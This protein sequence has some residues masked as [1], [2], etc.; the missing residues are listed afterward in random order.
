MQRILYLAIVCSMALSH[1]GI[2]QPRLALQVPFFIDLPD[3]IQGPVEATLNTFSFHDERGEFL[4]DQIAVQVPTRLGFA[5]APG[6]VLEVQVTA[7]GYWS[8]RYAL[9]RSLE[10]GPVRGQLFV[11]GRISGKLQVPTGEH[12]P[13]ALTARFQQAA[14]QQTDAPLP[15]GTVECP[16]V[17]GNFTCTLP[18]GK[19]DLRLRAAGFVS[20]Y[21]WNLNVAPGVNSPLGILQLERGGSVVGEVHGVMANTIG[22]IE[23]ALELVQGGGGVRKADKEQFVRLNL[24]T[25]PNSHGFFQIADVPQ[26]QYRVRAFHEKWGDAVSLPITVF[27]NGETRLKKPLA[28]RPLAAL[29]LLI[30]PP[31]DPYGQPWW[32]ELYQSNLAGTALGSQSAGPVPLSGLW[33]QDRLPQGAYDIRL[34]DSSGSSWLLHHIAVNTQHHQEEIHLP[35]LTIEGQVTLGGEPLA[36]NLWFGGRRGAQ[37]IKMWADQDGRFRGA[38]PV[39]DT[40]LVEVIVENPPLR[41]RLPR[42]ALEP[43]GEGIAEVHI[44]LGPLT[45]EGEI[46]DHEGRPLQGSVLLQSQDQ[47]WPEQV[48]TETDGKFQFPGLDAGSYSVQAVSAGFVA[49]SEKILLNLPEDGAFQR[50]VV[51]P[52]R[53][54]TG[55]VISRFGP[56]PGAMVL[57]IP[58][59]AQGKSAATVQPRHQTDV[60]GRFYLDIPFHTDH[61]ELTVAAPGYGLTKQRMKVVSDR[62]ITVPVYQQ[63]GTLI[64]ETGSDISLAEFWE[65]IQIWQ[66]DLPLTG[67]ELGPWINIQG[68]G[69]ASGSLVVP[70]L[71]PGNYKICL[72]Y[73]DGETCSQ[74][75]LAA[76]GEL[77]LVVD[78]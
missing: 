63:T 55:Q 2:A 56:V 40:W 26:G 66:E 48:L 22:K 72:H 43:T 29:D 4:E 5:V 44:A 39:R 49:S 17:E 11:A 75:F 62:P 16:V 10:A 35:M 45:L 3:G 7:P 34:Q 47:G 9:V 33:Q 6:R 51:Q 25:F 76:D 14:D 71:E 8:P 42:V 53:S 50:L 38:L 61:L 20:H 12:L 54:L 78:L 68:G 74:G 27:P 41:R 32:I 24:S 23:V 73:K 59:D 36:A 15:E 69:F 46:V 64:A 13:T 67:A 77:P 31:T 70:M 30:D 52:P 65:K 57:A 28:L 1:P 60:Q 37:S 21:R 19:V 58:K 18:E